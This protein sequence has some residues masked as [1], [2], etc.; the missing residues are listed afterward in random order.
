MLLSLYE[1]PFNNELGPD[2]NA[3]LFQ[4][5]LIGTDQKIKERIQLTIEKYEPSVKIKNLN[6]NTDSNLIK[7]N[8]EYFLSGNVP[9][10]TINLTMEKSR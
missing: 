1:K 6:I 7:I 8:L 9:L 4:N 2:L 3:F 5:Y 10:S